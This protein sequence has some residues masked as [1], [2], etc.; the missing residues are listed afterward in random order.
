[1][2]LADATMLPTERVAA[3]YFGDWTAGAAVPGDALIDNAYEGWDGLAQ[4]GQRRGRITMRGEGADALH[5]FRPPGADFFCAEPVSHLPDAINRGGMDI[6][7]PGETR[8][9]AMTLSA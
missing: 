6:L 5:L 8:T 9:L 3:A 7:A 4:I 2:W 1:M